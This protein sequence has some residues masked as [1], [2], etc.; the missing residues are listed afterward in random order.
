ML[1]VRGLTVEL[2]GRTILSEVSFDV[3]SGSIVGVFGES[4]CGKTTLALSL[5]GLL[6]SPPYRVAGSARLKDEELI[7]RPER[8]L[9]RLRGS[10]ASIVFQDPM[11]ALNPVLRIDRQLR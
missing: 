4:G 5:L 11:L 8:D 2:P 10:L 3:P 6:P 1:Q 7:G 9:Q